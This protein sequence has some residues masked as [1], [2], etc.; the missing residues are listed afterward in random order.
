MESITDDQDR[1]KSNKSRGMEALGTNTYLK[2]GYSSE[3]KNGWHD[4]SHSSSLLVAEWNR[5]VAR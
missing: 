1:S 2:V 5:L 3:C 4:K